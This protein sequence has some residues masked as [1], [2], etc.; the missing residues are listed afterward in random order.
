VCT[1]FAIA[2]LSK[3]AAHFRFALNTTL[4]YVNMRKE[5]ATVLAPT[6][7]GVL[8]IGSVVLMNSVLQADVGVSLYITITIGFPVALFVAVFCAIYLMPVLVKKNKYSY[9]IVGAIGLVIGLLIMSILSINKIAFVAGTAWA[10]L[11]AILFRWFTGNIQT[12]DKKI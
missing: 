6:L 8:V 2:A 3:C 5:A 9:F 10:G 4:D 12:T 1:T 11:S 7:G